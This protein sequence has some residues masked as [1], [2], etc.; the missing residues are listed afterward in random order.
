MSEEKRVVIWSCHGKYEDMF[1][2]D[3]G[4]HLQRTTEGHWRQVV[5]RLRGLLKNAE[6]SAAAGR[7]S[8]ALL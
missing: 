3:V 6:I 5:P 4:G 1:S 8:L 7:G 2:S